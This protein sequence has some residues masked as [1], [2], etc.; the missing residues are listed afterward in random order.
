MPNIWNAREVWSILEL[1][2]KTFRLGLNHAEVSSPK[3]LS[4]FWRSR[5]RS[6]QLFDFE[7]VCFLAPLRLQIKGLLSL[8]KNSAATTSCV[9]FCARPFRDTS[10][11]S[12]QLIKSSSFGYQKSKPNFTSQSQVGSSDSEF[13]ISVCFVLS[14]DKTGNDR[15]QPANWLIT[16]RSQ[17]Q[18]KPICSLD[19]AASEFESL[20]SRGLARTK[21]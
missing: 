9:V 19:A 1:A 2:Q 6:S 17:E 16:H 14:C 7:S 20:A 18:Q 11:C 10:V 15:R 5:S 12:I 8:F 3:T 13:W 21:T 4:H